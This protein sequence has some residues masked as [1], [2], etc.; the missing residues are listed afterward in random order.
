MAPSSVLRL[1]ES[2]LHTGEDIGDAKELLEPSV[3][4]S[5]LGRIVA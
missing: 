1:D 2:E 5:A 3:S 4:V